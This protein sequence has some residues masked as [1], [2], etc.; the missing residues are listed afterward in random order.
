MSIC[1]CP[2][3]LPQS[4]AYHKH[5]YPK[6]DYPSIQLSEHIQWGK[7]ANGRLISLWLAAQCRR[8]SPPLRWDVVVIVVVCRPAQTSG[9]ICC[10]A[11]DSPRR[12]EQRETRAL[13]G[14]GG[15]RRTCT[16][17]AP[18]SRLVI[19]R[20]HS[21]SVSAGDHLAEVRSGPRADQI[22]GSDYELLSAGPPV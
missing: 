2:C 11:S 12:T 5:R 7:V 17:R 22:I 13:S 21:S 3:H 19:K 9:T 4:A 10:C 18:R 16:L 6:W 8:G 20:R 14:G 1:R 15:A